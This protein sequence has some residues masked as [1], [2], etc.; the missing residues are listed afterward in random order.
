[1]VRPGIALQESRNSAPTL[2]QFALFVAFSTSISYT[3][4]SHDLSQLT[5]LSVDFSSDLGK[6]HPG[7]PGALPVLVLGGER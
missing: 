3:A 4:A 5:I 1:M 2:I 7:S 6:F